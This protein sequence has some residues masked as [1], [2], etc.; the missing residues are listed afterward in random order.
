M[1][2]LKEAVPLGLGPRDKRN[3][4]DWLK[5]KTV[6]PWIYE[7]IFLRNKHNFALC[8]NSFLVFTEIS[9]V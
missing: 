2:S 8:L 9:A 4:F 5:M 7:I 3:E 6:T 1:R